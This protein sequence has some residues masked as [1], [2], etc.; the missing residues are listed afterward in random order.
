VKDLPFK[1]ISKMAIPDLRGC[2][3]LSCCRAQGLNELEVLADTHSVFMRC[4]GTASRFEITWSDRK[5]QAALL[6]L[7][8]QIGA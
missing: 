2:S 8:Q 5:T 6:Q 4:G 1:T 3:S 7:L